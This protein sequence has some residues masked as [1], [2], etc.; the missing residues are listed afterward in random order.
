MYHRC[1]LMH[2]LVSVAARMCLTGFRM[3]SC[4]AYTPAQDMV[5]PRSEDSPRLEEECPRSEDSPPLEEECPRLE[6]SPRSDEGCPHSEESPDVSA[7]R[8]EDATPSDK[9]S[10]LKRAKVCSS[11]PSPSLI[12]GPRGVFSRRAGLLVLCQTCR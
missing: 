1:K 3:T 8:A 5:S 10:T 9:E 12:F 7:P 11:L 2:R 6:D 4:T